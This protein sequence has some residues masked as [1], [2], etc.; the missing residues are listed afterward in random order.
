MPYAGAGAIRSVSFSVCIMTA[1]YDSVSMST[2]DNR[3]RDPVYS[4]ASLKGVTGTAPGVN[5]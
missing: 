1:L 3:S 5:L 4:G 2:S